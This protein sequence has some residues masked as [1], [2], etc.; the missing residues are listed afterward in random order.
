MV[1]KRFIGK[2]LPIAIISAWMVFLLSLDCAGESNAVAEMHRDFPNLQ[3]CSDCHQDPHK[4][5]MPYGC[6]ACHV[7]ETWSKMKDGI[8]HSGE[9]PLSGRHQTLP[10]ADCH[11]NSSFKG[12]PKDCQVCHWQRRQDDPY[13]TRLGSDCA[14]CHSPEGWAP[15]NWNHT[16]ETGFTLT[17]AHRGIACDQCHKNLVFKNTA[18]DCSKCHA[19]DYN[20]VRDPDHRAGDFP[21]DCAL[22]HTTGSWKGAR[23]T[24]D[25]SGFPLTGG[26]AGLDCSQCHTSSV[27]TG[28]STECVSCHADDYAGTRN[29]DHRA[30][31]FPTDCIQCHDV[32]A[33]TD[34]RFDHG[35]TGYT[36]TGAHK[37]VAC[38]DCHTAGTYAG[39]P[40]ECSACHADDYA[41]TT[42]PDHAAAGYG[43]DCSLC[44][45]TDS[46]QTGEFNHPGMELV[47]GHSG[48]DCTA[49]HSNGQYQGTPRECAGCHTDDY[50]A[51]TNPRHDAAGFSKD[52]QT[53]HDVFS[54][55]N[56]RFDHS[57]T[58]YPLTGMHIGVDCNACHTAGIYNGLNTA[59]FSCHSDDYSGAQDPNHSAAGFSSDC[60]LCHNTSG[61]EN[62]TFNHNSTGYA[63]TGAHASVDCVACHP[64]NR[65]KGTPRDCFSCH[66]EDYRNADDHSGYPTDCEQCHTTD[67]WEHSRFRRPALQAPLR[68]SK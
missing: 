22:C 28:L 16:I 57:T 26:H 44:H 3:S 7:P 35:T 23:Y 67:S 55:D 58:D 13:Q 15:A 65:Y 49:C 25:S 40:Q 20:G 9:F 47:G 8:P 46:W 60:T 4:G 36:L 12:T 37:T 68:R 18:A 24:H 30:A 43:M 50:E 54:W 19:D 5:Q 29:P 48:L 21:K 1:L 52:C 51:S 63:L 2:S 34:G 45:S 33:W 66:E 11:I 38:N 39:T 10:C 59:C 17:G 14:R 42:D 61:W 64:N 62:D 41:R 6:S 56:G 27:F 32:T 31:G 53:C